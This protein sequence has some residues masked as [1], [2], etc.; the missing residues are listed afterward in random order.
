MACDRDGG[1]VDVS[2]HLNENGW[3]AILWANYD[4]DDDPP[5]AV[6]ALPRKYDEATFPHCYYAARALDELRPEQGQARDAGQASV[7]LH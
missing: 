4:T 1:P 6:F 3:T 2:V 5:R 7:W